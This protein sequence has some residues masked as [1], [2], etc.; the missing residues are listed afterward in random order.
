MWQNTY[1]VKKKEETKRNKTKND[2]VLFCKSEF[3]IHKLVLFAS[4]CT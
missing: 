2:D 4:L 1:F 3:T